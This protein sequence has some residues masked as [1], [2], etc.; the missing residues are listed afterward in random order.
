MAVQRPT[1]ARN[2]RL[3]RAGVARDEG[4]HEQDGLRRRALLRRSAQQ[5]SRCVRH[6][7]LPGA[8]RRPGHRLHELPSS[9][10]QRPLPERSLDEHHAQRPRVQRVGETSPKRA[11]VRAWV[12]LLRCSVRLCGTL[13]TRRGCGAEC[14]VPRLAR[15]PKIAHPHVFAFSH[16][17]ILWLEV[18][19]NDAARMHVRNCLQH[20]DQNAGHSALA[21]RDRR[22]IEL[23]EPVA[24]CSREE[25]HLQVAVVMAAKEALHGHDQRVPQRSLRLRLPEEI[26]RECHLLEHARLAR[27]SIHAR[28]NAGALVR[29][30]DAQVADVV[31]GRACIPQRDARRSERGALQ[32]LGRHVIIRSQGCHLRI[33]LEKLS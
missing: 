6:A 11:R 27:A 26:R 12:E 15:Q 3:A 8:R 4:W 28:V 5:R 18:A 2:R 25:R 9:A 13:G 22:G 23:L 20:L 17:D 7:A 1:R 32:G 10:Q 29:D 31:A 33:C 24:H 30:E 14:L 21:D 16:E 19:M